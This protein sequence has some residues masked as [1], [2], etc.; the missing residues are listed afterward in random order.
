[1]TVSKL[2]TDTG[3]D[4][5]VGITGRT[6][7]QA[8]VI[9]EDGVHKLVTKSSIVPEGLG[10]LFFLQATNNGSTELAVNGQGSPVT[11]TINAESGIGAQNLVV[12]ELRFHGFDNGVKTTTFMGTNSGL[13]NGVQVNIVSGGIT[14]TFLPIRITADFDAHFAFG[15]GG[16]FEV[17]IASGGDYVTATFSPRN[18]FVLEKDTSD[19]IE[20]IIQDNISQVSTL[21]LV[22][23]GFKT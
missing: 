17:V 2:N 15:D 19:R 1:M 3:Q 6:G 9:D 22:S 10:D 5:E 18:P 13:A 16:K 23:F 11:F 8:D 4:Y 20:I 7:L 12:Q 21:E 14:S